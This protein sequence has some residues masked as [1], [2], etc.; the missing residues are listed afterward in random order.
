MIC[1]YM[2]LKKNLIFLVFFGILIT[3]CEK[4]KY[5]RE[6]DGHN[7]ISIVNNSA[8][9]ITYTP[10]NGDSVYQYNGEFSNTIIQPYTS[11]NYTKTKITCWEEVLE[12]NNT[13]F[14]YLLIFDQDTVN[15]IGWQNISGTNRGLLKSF[16]INS[17]ILKQNNFTLTYEE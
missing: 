3:S 9:L 2:L 13:Q 7:A 8:R 5:C 15:A 12:T 4:S 14:E 16:K 17:E 11:D 6:I 10:L 1:K